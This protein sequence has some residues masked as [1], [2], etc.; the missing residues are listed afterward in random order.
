MLAKVKKGLNHKGNQRHEGKRRKNFVDFVLFVVKK[1][2]IYIQNLRDLLS[3]SKR[4]GQEKRPQRLVMV[5]FQLSH[6][7][8]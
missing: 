3:F 1:R 8:F 2:E 6:L 4:R 7:D 5:H